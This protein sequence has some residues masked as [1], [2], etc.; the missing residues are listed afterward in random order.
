M[1]PKRGLYVIELKQVAGYYFV[2]ERTEQMRQA[3]PF[4]CQDTT[5]AETHECPDVVLNY[6]P[7]KT[8]PE[9]RFSRCCSTVADWSG[10]SD[11]TET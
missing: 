7:E 2:Y 9:G 6:L 8:G 3:F 1:L 10:M 4:N 5:E 11:N